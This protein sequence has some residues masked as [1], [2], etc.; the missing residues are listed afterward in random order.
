[1]RNGIISKM[2]L[3]W[4]RLFFRV[5]SHCHMGLAALALSPPLF[6]LAHPKLRFGLSYD[7]I[8]SSALSDSLQF[9]R[10]PLRQDGARRALSVP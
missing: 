5:S 2:S 8:M 3:K 6:V 1:M 9:S 4:T 10:T 7:K